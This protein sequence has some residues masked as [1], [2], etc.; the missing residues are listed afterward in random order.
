MRG[1][2][3]GGGPEEGVVVGEEGEEDSEE[4]GCGCLRWEGGQRGLVRGLRGRRGGFGTAENHESREGLGAVS[5]RHT[6][7]IRFCRPFEIKRFAAGVYPQAS[8]V[9][10]VRGEVM[11]RCI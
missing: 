9:I 11:F 3:Q 4:E 8:K 7:E 1:W 10:C 2:C 5:Y 6:G